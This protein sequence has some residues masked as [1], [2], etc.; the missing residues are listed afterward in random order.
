MG[1]LRGRAEPSGEP[2]GSEHPGSRAESPRR[3]RSDL[4]LMSSG[5]R[6]QGGNE[7]SGTVLRVEEKVALN[8]LA[9]RKQGLRDDPP[10]S[11]P[12]LDALRPPSRI[13]RVWGRGRDTP[14]TSIA[15]FWSLGDDPASGGVGFV[16]GLR[17]LVL[18][19]RTSRT[20]KRVQ[21]SWL[22]VLPITQLI[23]QILLL[24]H[25]QVLLYLVLQM[26]H[27][28]T[29]QVLQ[30]LTPHEKPPAIGPMGYPLRDGRQ[31]PS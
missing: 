7:A 29:H 27:V 15:L 25:I 14:A 20:L 18:L 16:F 13:V 9:P 22:S 12:L 6:K 3:E 28:Q 4:R 11:P 8:G 17:A 10:R 24:L 26:H 5:L 1:L 31:A 23:V 2:M 21:R 19:E 30:V